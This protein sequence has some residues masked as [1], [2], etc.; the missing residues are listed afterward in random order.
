MIPVSQGKPYA[1]NPHVR[2]EEGASAQAA[3]RRSA[4]LHHNL[5]NR[6]TGTRNIVCVALRIFFGLWGDADM[7][8]NRVSGAWQMGWGMVASAW[9]EG[10][11][12]KC[13]PK[14]ILEPE[15]DLKLKFSS[16]TSA[17]LAAQSAS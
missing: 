3:P 11:D 2:F 9:L 10:A 12:P 8:A 1:G 15:I 13:Q 5:R 16:F 14:D 6:L 7:A 17:D 4:L